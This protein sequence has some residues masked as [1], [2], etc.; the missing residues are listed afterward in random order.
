MN[1]KFNLLKIKITDEFNTP[2]IDIKGKPR[3][4]KE[5]LEFLELKFK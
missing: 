5:A 4:I 2:I 1:K 3:K